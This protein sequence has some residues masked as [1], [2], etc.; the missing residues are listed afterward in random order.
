MEVFTI[1]INPIA[2]FTTATPGKK[3]SI[4]KQQKTPSTFHVARYR[5]AKA[6]MLKSIKDGLTDAE[7]MAGIDRLTN[8][9]TSTDFQKNDVKNSIEAL[10][11]FLHLTFPKEFTSI[12]CSFPKAETKVVMLADVNI[13]VAPDLILKW[14]RDGK[15]FVGGIKFHISKSNVF[16]L[17]NSKCAAAGL[18][19]FLENHVAEKDETVDPK[20]CLSVD[21][22]GERVTP[23]PYDMKAYLKK[24]VEAC[25]EVKLLWKVA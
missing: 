20:F 10:K 19:L 17:E 15:S 4:V 8:K 12:K 9:V 5:T 13:L 25:E 11:S 22:F 16:E 21:I 23:A 6:S 24:L 1:S 3:K 7:I 18:R 14:K 2:V